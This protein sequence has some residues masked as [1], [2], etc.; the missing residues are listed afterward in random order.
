MVNLEVI[1]KIYKQVKK[2]KNDGINAQYIPDL[3]KV[4]PN[5]FAIS[6]C[7][8]DGT[9]YNFGDS[10]KEIGL[11]SCSK[12]FNLA[13]ALKKYGTNTLQDKIGTYSSSY[14][15]NSIVAA[16]N[17]ENHTINSFNN[18]G[19]IATV[20]LMYQKNQ[21]NQ[22]KFEKEL[23]DNINDFAGRKLKT[24]EHLY[25]SE[26]S[27]N[28][29]NLSIVYLLKGYNRFYG[30]V[31]PCVEAYTKMCSLMV[32]SK[33]ASIMAATLANKGQNPLTKKTIIDKKEEVHYILTHMLTNGMYTESEKW[34]T[35]IGLPA[36]SGVGGM[37]I[38]VVP[39]VMGIGIVSPP[40]NKA[41]NS[42][43]GVVAAKMIAHQL[44][45]NLYTTVL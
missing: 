17:I 2:M 14:D 40:L 37:I 39:G 26:M 29:H 13:L 32:T 11:E 12:V 10:E 21:K 20:S 6:I 42:Y 9:T 25:E 45:L 8:L 35:D 5:I 28:D 34:M 23:H 19:A 43:K 16:N 15:F 41:G 24:N 31:I 18:G 33:D 22:K 27:T 1:D 30:E 3:A 36:K 44:N 38:I 4:N 7:M